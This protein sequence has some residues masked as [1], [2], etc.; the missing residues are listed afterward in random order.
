MKY[1]LSLLL[2]VLFSA[3]YVN[4][5]AK[6]EDT[7]YFLTR[8][9]NDTLAIER[10]NITG[11]AISAT[12]VLRSPRI[13]VQESQLEF[14]QNGNMKNYLREV[15]NPRTDSVLFMEE[16]WWDYDSLRI[17]RV[18]GGEEQTYSQA[19][20]KNAVPFIDMVHWP[21]D[22]MLTNAF[23]ASG[24]FEQPVFSGG[25][26]FEFEIT[27]V[28]DDSMTVRHPSRGVMGVTTATGKLQFLEAKRTT[29]AL[30][31]TK[32]ADLPLDDLIERF[33]KLD[34]S[35]AFGSLS[36]RGEFAQ[37]VDGVSYEIDYGTPSK[38]GR[39]IWGSLV[40]FDQVWRTGANRATHFTVSDD[41]VV[42]NVKVPAG[43]Y[44]LFTIP[45]S[46]GGQLIINK[47]TGQNGQRYDATQDLG[48][49]EMM[50]R[51]LVDEVEVFTI[52]V[53]ENSELV[54]QWD[55]TEYVVP[56]TR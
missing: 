55:K 52:L 50:A 10:V 33:T 56:I 43:S 27:S 38:R 26:G 20:P 54:L 15:I 36:G 16:A 21:F 3:C 46:T 34:E 29:R 4:D 11:D 18:R 22:I 32:V 35:R 6:V 12:V 45:T 31:V 40:R 53:N 28:R 51:P 39:E 17:K 9:G 5:M 49:T 25:R 44:T 7:Y 48:R 19:A 30:T 41:V 24:T 1:L 37:E 8:L 23:K 47:Q 14:D 2:L 13:S 42:G